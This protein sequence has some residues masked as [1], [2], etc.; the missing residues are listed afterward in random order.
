V[1]G[2]AAFELAGTSSSSSSSPQ[3]PELQLQ[4]LSLQESSSAAEL[5]SA[6]NG[7][8][9]TPVIDEAPGDDVGT[10]AGDVQI[11]P[12]SSDRSHHMQQALPALRKSITD[13]VS[14]QLLLYEM[15]MQ[16]YDLS[17]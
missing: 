15:C 5:A 11:T 3:P 8:P 6:G 10:S 9:V 7:G 14:L 17:M 4:G 12:P 1:F 16:Q 13:M 2:C